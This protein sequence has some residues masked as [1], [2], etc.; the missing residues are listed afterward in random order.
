M[1]LHAYRL[2]N[3]SLA[4]KKA[5][6]LIE[7][8]GL[9]GFT[10]KLS[11]AQELVARLMGYD[12]WSELVHITRTSPERGVPD[13]MLPPKSVTLRK[14][15]QTAL[16]VE[17][18]AVDEWGADTLIR[19]LAPTG[20]A[21]GSAAQTV[22]RLGLR[23]TEED[24]AWLEKSMVLV[25]AFDAAARPLY[26]LG[27]SRDEGLTHVRIE[28]LVMGRQQFH[29]RRVTVPEDIIAWVARGFP[30]N[31]PLA[32]EALEQAVQYANAA[33]SAFFLLDT[34][35]RALG[36][37]PMIAPI[38]WTFIMLFRTRVV[39][40]ANSHFTALSPEPALHI[41]FDLPNFFVNPENEW[42]ASRALSLQLAL[43]REFLDSGWTGQGT[44]WEVTFRDGNS[45]KEDI[46]VRATSAGAAC[47]WAAAA[48]GALRIAKQQIPGSFSLISIVGENGHEDRETAL[49]AAKNETVIRRGKLIDAAKL[50]IRGQ[51]KVA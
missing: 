44:E 5:K 9:M 30:E 25:R 13:Q 31:A 38:D 49:A 39:A 12:N 6:K 26:S 41:G 14:Q 2:L 23:L 3:D 19:A 51:R 47:A 17:E 27:T 40:G 35:I 1:H 36:P 22:E 21:A 15:F 28:N 20:E 4:K 8:A 24:D 48:R 50:R 43:R 45:S 42:N 7:I 29:G 33:H 18:F 37:A 11:R 46:K 16:L 34:R 10:I 32:G